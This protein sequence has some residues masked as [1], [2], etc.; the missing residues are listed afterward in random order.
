MEFKKSYIEQLA[1]YI[2]KNLKKGYTIDSLK[3]SL[4]NQGYSKI[5]VENAV[6]HANRKLAR[7]APQMKE[8]P[9]ITYKVHD[10]P[11][12][13]V[14]RKGIIKEKEIQDEE[15]YTTNYND[16]EK[17]SFLKKVFRS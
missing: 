7:T 10:Q 16:S 15:A 9:E 1:E 11:D 14:E 4:I 17:K 12:L 3:I 5:S 6:Q 8:K 13:E 2:I